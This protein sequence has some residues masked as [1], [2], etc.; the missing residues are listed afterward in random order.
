M[1][2]QSG[3]IPGF[4]LIRSLGLINSMWAI[5]LPTAFSMWNIIILRANFSTIPESI[6]ESVRMDGGNDLCIFFRFVLPLSKAILATIA[7]FVSVNQWNNFF[8][9]F[10]FLNDPDKQTLSIILRKIV[11]QNNIQSVGW[12]EAVS[13]LQVGPGF[14]KK[15]EMGTI[16]V[17]IGPII[18]LYPFVQ[19][20]FIKG[21]LIGSIKG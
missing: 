21:V 2:I 13:G 11:L 4:L 18:L 12:R 20:Y 10:L 1:F 19:K 9:P 6:I 5:V 3:M 14:I 17:S 7:L 15:V 8:G 16:I